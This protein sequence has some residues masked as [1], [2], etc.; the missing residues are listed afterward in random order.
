M[1]L[2]SASKSLVVGMNAHDE[3]DGA[4]AIAGLLLD[5]RNLFLPEQAFT[6]VRNRAADM[7]RP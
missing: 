7:S 5:G 1:G 2:A 3:F 6:R 4:P